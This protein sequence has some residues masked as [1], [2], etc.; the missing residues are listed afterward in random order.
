M[1]FYHIQALRNVAL[2]LVASFVVPRIVTMDQAVRQH[3]AK[4]QWRQCAL[5]VSKVLA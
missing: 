3:V 5:M 2:R 1:D 4:P